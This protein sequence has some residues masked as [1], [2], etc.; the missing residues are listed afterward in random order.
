MVPTDL[1]GLQSAA[2][3]AEFARVAA[4]YPADTPC[5]GERVRLQ[6]SFGAR[7]STRET[8]ALLTAWPMEPGT[9]TLATAAPPAAN[10]DVIVLMAPIDECVVCAVATPLTNLRRGKVRVTAFGWPSKPTVYTERGVHVG[11][12]H[13]KT[14]PECG[15]AHHYSYAEGGTKLEAGKVMPYAKSTSQE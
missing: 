9:E 13:L 10:N 6:L 4:A 3:V 1:A 11:E 14:C 12:L 7:M 5:R 8:L 15:A 2:E